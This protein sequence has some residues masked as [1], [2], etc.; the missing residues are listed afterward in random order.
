MVADYKAKHGSLDAAF[1]QD[2][3]VWYNKDKGLSTQ[4][5]FVKLIKKTSAK[6]V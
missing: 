3:Q 5:D 1:K 6:E 4:D 2:L